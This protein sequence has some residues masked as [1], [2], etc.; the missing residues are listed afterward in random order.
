MRGALKL[1][2]TPGRATAMAIAA[3][4]LA[5]LSVCVSAGKG[6]QKY[7]V[8]EDVP[9]FANKV[10]PFNNPSETYQYYSLP[11][12]KPKDGAKYKVSLHAPFQ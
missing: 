2:K 8:H 7:K 11:F 6:S 5:L 12:C 9:L 10:G 3:V 4:T 1:P